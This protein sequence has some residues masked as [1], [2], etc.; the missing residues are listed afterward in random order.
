MGNA[1]YR[2]ILK[3]G[4]DVWNEWKKDNLFGYITWL[5]ELTNS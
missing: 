4:V 1:K 2:E 5:T 3:R